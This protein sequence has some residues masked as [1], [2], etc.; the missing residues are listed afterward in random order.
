MG[1]TFDA[2]RG[3]RRCGGIDRQ[4]MEVAVD[5]R[6]VWLATKHDAPYASSGAVSIPADP[7]ATSRY[8]GQEV[9]FSAQYQVKEGVAAG[10]GCARLFSGRFLKTASPGKD[11][12][13]PLV[14]VS[15]IPLLG[16]RRCKVQYLGRGI[17]CRIA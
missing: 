15:D 16:R 5:L 4:E 17:T 2:V 11:Y 14:S 3:T 9:D 10:F 12:T 6:N 8:L 7:K 13:Y 1:R